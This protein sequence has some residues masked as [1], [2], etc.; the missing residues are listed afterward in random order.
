MKPQVEVLELLRSLDATKAIVTAGS[1]RNQQRKYRAAG[2]EAAIPSKNVFYCLVGKSKTRPI[3]NAL[4]HLGFLARETLFV[5]DDPEY[6]IHSA[7]RAGCRTAWLSHGRSYPANL[8]QPTF[9]LNS[10]F[11][12]SEHLHG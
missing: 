9:T 5:G 2:L 7:H 1:R 4:E 3:L 10:L 6:D 8:P 11:E 12:L